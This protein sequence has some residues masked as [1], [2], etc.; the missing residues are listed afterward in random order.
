MA[1]FRFSQVNSSTFIMFPYQQVFTFCLSV[2]MSLCLYLCLSVCL[3][4]WLS[5]C[6][7]ECLSVNV[8]FVYLY[9]YLQVPI[10][11]FVCL[12]FNPY[13]FIIIYRFVFMAVWLHMSAWMQFTCLS[14]W[15]PTKILDV[16]KVVFS[17]LNTCIQHSMLREVSR[18]ACHVKYPAQ[19]AAISIQH[20]IQR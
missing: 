6:L 9:F 12:F 16:R 3:S 15:S 20:S 1:L 2:Y 5:L 18:T 4:L 10:P 17:C 7:S 19:Y 14:K 13:V 8:Y 11:L